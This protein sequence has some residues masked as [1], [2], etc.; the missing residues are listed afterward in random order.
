MNNTNGCLHPIEHAFVVLLLMYYV[1]A[2][3][4]APTLLQ[5][6]QKSQQKIKTG[7]SVSNPVYSKED[8]VIVGYGQGNGF[9]P[10][11]WALISFII[12]KMC[13]TKRYGKTVTTPIS[14]QEI[15]LLGFTFVDDVDLISGANNIH[16]TSTTMIAR[17]QALMTCWNSGTRAT[18]GLIAPKNTQW[19][20]FDFFWDRLNWVYDTLLGDITL[21][22]KNGVPYTVTRHTSLGIKV[23]LTGNQDAEL[24]ILTNV[25]ELFSTQ[26]RAASVIKC[27]V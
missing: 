8:L 5:V 7:Y 20:L 14:I 22:D 1:V 6:F 9:G 10:A 18:S 4:V 21:P 17:F 11:I 16:T 26:M 13:K 12:I 3:W 15:S 27:H 24:F 2:W 23:Y 19:F 25:A